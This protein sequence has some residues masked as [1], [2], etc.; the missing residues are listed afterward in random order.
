MQDTCPSAASR[1]AL[2]NRPLGAASALLLVALSGCHSAPAA[3]AFAATPNDKSTEAQLRR[4]D[5]M[6]P[7][8]PFDEGFGAATL[9][10]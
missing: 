6:A 7:I 2:P 4:V 8:L 9:P 1:A 10:P 3:N 5:S